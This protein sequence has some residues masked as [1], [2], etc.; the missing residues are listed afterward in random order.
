MTLLALAM[1]LLSAKVN[2]FS[3]VNV[4]RLQQNDKFTNPNHTAVSKCLASGQPSY[5][6][7]SCKTFRSTD[8]R[9]KCLSSNSCCGSCECEDDYPIY[10]LHLGKCVNLQELNS[11]AFGQG[12]TGMSSFILRNLLSTATGQIRNLLYIIERSYYPIRLLRG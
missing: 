6:A 10:L 12:S 1:L 2:S 8:T 11:D 5:F 4:T 3:S 9:A 7:D